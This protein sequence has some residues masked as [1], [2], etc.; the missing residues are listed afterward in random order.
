MKRTIFMMTILLTAFSAAPVFAGED[1]IIGLVTG[2]TLGSIIGNQFGHGG[3]RIAFTTTG[4]LAGGWIGND[5][6]QSMDNRVLD[7]RVLDN[8]AA[9]RTGPQA[10]HS[11]SSSPPVYQPTSYKPNYVAPDAPAPESIYD[12][13]YQSYCRAYSEQMRIGNAIHETY[14]TACLQ[15]DG[16]WRAVE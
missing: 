4:A 12:Q 2:A 5:I 10:V 1:Q 9:R 16:T 13:G 6:G 3:G 11:I 14:G 15:P 8:S 7:S